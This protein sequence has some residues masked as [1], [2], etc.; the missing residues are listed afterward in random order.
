VHSSHCS[1]SCSQARKLACKVRDEYQH[2]AEGPYGQGM[3]GA[4]RADKDGKLESATATALVVGSHDQQHM[5]E[6]QAAK[7]ARDVR[8]SSCL[9]PLPYSAL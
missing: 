9:R 2:L 8:S 1:H 3:D 4:V 5:S 6:S 7:R